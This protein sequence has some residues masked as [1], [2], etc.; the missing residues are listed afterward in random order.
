MENGSNPNIIQRTRAFLG[1]HKTCQ[2][3]YPSVKFKFAVKTQAN[4]WRMKLRTRSMLNM[5]WFWV[6]E[7]NLCGIYYPV[8][9]FKRLSHRVGINTK[10]ILV[11]MLKAY[12][13]HW[14]PFG[15][16]HLPSRPAYSWPWNCTAFCHYTAFFHS[17]KPYIS[18][19]VRFLWPR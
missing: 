4:L 1:T 17:D 12:W 13:K 11:T 6:F 15:F 5:H 2:R 9:W 8:R 16:K 18:L 3:V 14:I 19:R 7:I 10:F